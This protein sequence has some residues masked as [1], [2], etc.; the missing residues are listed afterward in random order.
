MPNYS[1]TKLYELISHDQQG[2]PVVYRGHTTQPLH[3]RLCEHQT[4]YKAWVKDNTKE[5]YSS[6]E[7]LKHG[8]ARIE[9]VRTVCC[10]NVME[11]KRAEGVFIREVPCVNKHIAGRTLKEWWQDN[12]DVLLAKK[13][14]YDQANKEKKKAYN[15]ANKQAQREYQREYREWKRIENFI[16][17]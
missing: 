17:S 16:W 15:E 13:K 14:T 3:K 1:E 4:R 9:L 8:N 10:N 11:A 7:V 5:Y 12:K 2:N 6:Y